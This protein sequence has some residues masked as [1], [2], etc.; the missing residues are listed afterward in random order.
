MLPVGLEGAIKD[1]GSVPKGIVTGAGIVAGS[2]YKQA[3]ESPAQF[4]GEMIG[5]AAIGKLGSA[6]KNKASLV[7]KEYLPPEKIIRP[8]VLSGAKE[9]PLA[10]KGTTASQLIK[11]FETSPYRYPRTEVPGG[12]H[13][14]PQRF[15]AET[16]SQPGSSSVVGLHLGPDVSPHFLGVSEKGGIPKVKLFG[17]GE[18]ARRPAANWVD[19]QNIRS[20]PEGIRGKGA[21]V[22]NEYLMNQ[23]P[24]GQGYVTPKFESL[25]KQRAAERE[26]VVPP[27]TELIRTESKYYTKFRGK[28]VPVDRYQARPENAPQG[29][30]SLSGLGDIRRSNKRVTA[31]DLY[32]ESEYYRSIGDNRYPIFTPG[33]TLP[34]GAGYAP[35]PE[36]YTRQVRSADLYPPSGKYTS[37]NPV[38]FG[39]SRPYQGSYP[40]SHQGP[41]PGPEPIPPYSEGSHGSRDSVIDSVIFEDQSGRG[42]RKKIAAPNDNN[43]RNLLTTPSGGWGFR[44][45]KHYVQD[46]LSLITGRRRL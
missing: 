38:E 29:K 14:T 27:G 25:I 39:T 37:L 11:D 44:Q 4:A 12:W 36:H 5:M 7:G 21:A 23:A 19:V 10:P 3:K 1:P 18:T 17:W 6:A 13:A 46:P 2:L 15:A 32:K 43:V 33:R 45:K 24:K 16:I 30:I 9:F 26:I 31:E 35:K 28:E 8:E 22:T 34:L 42:S 41:Y 40:R 20:L